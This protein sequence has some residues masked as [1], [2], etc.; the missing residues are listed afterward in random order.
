[1]VYDCRGNHRY[2]LHTSRRPNTVATCRLP[3]TPFLLLLLLTA[4]IVLVASR[5]LLAGHGTYQMLI[6][7]G[8]PPSS[9]LLGSICARQDTLLTSTNLGTRVLYPS[10]Y[11]F[12]GVVRFALWSQIPGWMISRLAGPLLLWA[13]AFGASIL[14]FRYTGSHVASTSRAAILSAA[15]GSLYALSP[16]TFDELAA[17]HIYYLVATAAIPFLLVI[18]ARRPG[19]ITAFHLLTAGLLAS[20]IFSQVQYF[21]ILPLVLV[22]F[23]LW[24]GVTLQYYINGLAAF[25]I[26]I[27]A[28][29]PWSLPDLIYPVQITISNYFTP[30]DLVGLSVSPLNAIRMLGYPTPFY[31]ITTGIM[32]PIVSTVLVSMFLISVISIWHLSVARRMSVGAII[33]LVIV[34]VW[35]ARGAPF[36]AQWSRLLPFELTGLLRERYSLLAVISVFVVLGFASACFHV[37][38]RY[39]WMGLSSAVIGLVIGAWGFWNGHLGPY[40]INRSTYPDQSRVS[41]MIAS[42]QRTAGGSVLTIPTGSIVEERGWPAFGRSPFSLGG[43]ATVLD[44]EGASVNVADL[45]GTLATTLSTIQGC[46]AAEPLLTELNVRYVV[47]WKYLV[48]NTKINRTLVLENLKHCGFRTVYSDV[49]SLVLMDSA[50]RF[51]QQTSS[52]YITVGSQGTGSNAGLASLW[53]SPEINLAPNVKRARLLPI[54]GVAHIGTRNIDFKG[55]LKSLQWEEPVLDSQGGGLEG[56]R[57]LYEL[58]ENRLNAGQLVFSDGAPILHAGVDLNVSGPVNKIYLGKRVV[59]P[60]TDAAASASANLQDTSN[61]HGATLAESGIAAVIGNS[62]TVTLKASAD[63]AGL[64]IRLPIHRSAY[65]DIAIQILSNAGTHAWA[66]LVVNGT[67]DLYTTPARGA[68]GLLVL[69][70]T[71]PANTASLYIYIYQPAGGEVT[72]GTISGEYFVVTSHVPVT[73]LAPS[74]FKF[75]RTTPY[76]QPLPLATTKLSATS[77]ELAAA[78]VQ[79]VDNVD[80]L[81]LAAAGVAASVAQTPQGPILKIHD[82]Y[83]SAG[84]GIQVIAASGDTVCGTL[85]HRGS[86]LSSARML[87]ILGNEVIGA[88]NWIASEVRWSSTKL[89]ATV[90][91]TGANPYLYIDARSQSGHTS[92]VE[93]KDLSIEIFGPLPTIIPDARLTINYVR[94]SHFIVSAPSRDW[95]Y[96]HTA[97]DKYYSLPAGLAVLRFPSS[98]NGLGNTW[99]AVHPISGTRIVYKPKVLFLH[100][101][102]IFRYILLSFFVWLAGA[103]VWAR[104][105]SNRRSHDG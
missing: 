33:L 55:G 91:S 104:Y 38:Q 93:F 96:L 43:P 87:L 72:I 94:H 6:D 77:L 24:T 50:L 62:G 69:E 36:Y 31:E 39:R 25:T 54:G 48:G 41:S 101:L 70:G 9:R 100:L 64:P 3:R 20:L 59:L 83:D 7:P 97:Y 8:L 56:G 71:V 98:P 29:L 57:L 92:L 12:C 34:Y 76:R 13:A 105:K 22:I 79:N 49:Q 44:S 37:E 28:Q 2:L 81:S 18:L 5:G 1:M 47:D 90:P 42:Y 68:P 63:E 19:R 61:V 46:R 65:L 80:R 30:S 60:L 66:A 4:T 84:V 16:F 86:S 11:I 26:G 88:T 74:G 85:R 51:P 89:C 99:L 40:G 75:S 14:C 78:N 45:V 21:I 95:V 52:R 27:L 103:L 102:G 53:N 67:E 15:V 17:S 73:Q 58:Q 10:S 82:R 23:G 32:L 35:G